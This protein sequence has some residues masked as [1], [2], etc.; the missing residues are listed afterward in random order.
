[1]Q[2]LRTFLNSDNFTK[3]FELF[4][5][6]AILASVLRFAIDTLPDLEPATRSLVDSAEFL[7]VL[8][9]TLEYAIRL[10]R[11]EKPLRYALS[12]FGIIDLL[13][14]APYY[15]TALLGLQPLRLLVL[16][17]LLRILKLTRYL[18]ALRRFSSA[19]H[20]TREELVIFFAASTIIIFL[21]AVGIY[22][23]EHQAQPDAFRNFFDALW[24][25]VVTLTTVGYGDLYP[26]TVG[27]RLFTFVVLLTGLGLIAVPTGII[28]SSLNSIRQENANEDKDRA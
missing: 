24:W 26:I 27:G 11:E 18:T 22:H 9:F 2:G 15:I 6:I 4:I 3:S 10:F 7:F 19:L 14:I 20:E 23:F 5:A 17:R 28:A 21:S 8:V 25:S 12:F 1:M 13:A 16:F